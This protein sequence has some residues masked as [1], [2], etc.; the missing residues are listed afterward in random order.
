MAFNPVKWLSTPTQ[1][2]GPFGVWGAPASELDRFMDCD[3]FLEDPDQVMVR[4]K[5]VDAPAD[6]LFR[7]LTQ[8]RAAP[9][10]YDWIDNAG[11]RSPDHLIEPAEPLEVGQ[12]IAKIFKLVAFEPDRSLTMLTRGAVFGTTVITYASEPVTETTSRL[13]G[14]LLIKY[15]RNPLGAGLSLVL[16]AGDLVMMRRQMLNFA[17]LAEGSVTAEPVT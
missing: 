2:T 13:F 5:E 12:R 7:W 10:S 8:M 11:K 14:R 1:A 15:N 4:A 17:R 9:Y 3:D 16:P 6:H